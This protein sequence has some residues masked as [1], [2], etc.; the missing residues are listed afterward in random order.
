MVHADNIIVLEKGRIVEQGTHA[1][2]LE[3]D[4]LYAGMWQRQR[5]AD[6]AR[7]KLAT[8]LGHDEQRR[9]EQRHAR[10]VEAVK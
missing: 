7:E 10:G 3:L 1:S 4:G 5:E 8:V 6:E 2:L 9:S